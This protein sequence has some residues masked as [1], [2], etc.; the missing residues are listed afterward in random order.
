[1]RF[2]FTIMKSKIDCLKRCFFETDHG[3]LFEAMERLKI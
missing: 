1:M 3:Y 2:Y